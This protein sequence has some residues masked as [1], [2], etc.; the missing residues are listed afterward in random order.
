MRGIKMHKIKQTQHGF[1][2]TPLYRV[3]AGMVKRCE[4]VKCKG[5][6]Y[7]GGRGITLHKK[8]RD[9]AGLFCLWALD[10]GYK[11]GLEID[12]IDNDGDY[13]PDNCRFVTHRQNC[14]TGRRVLF[15]N[16]KTGMTGV[17]LSEYG[18]FRVYQQV[19]GK[20]KYIGV[21]KTLEEAKKVRMSLC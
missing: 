19:D 6:K 15:K 11:K 4:D 14:Q 9:N 13:A 8:W 7:Y 16:N 5:Y 12:R 10:N 21:Y 20:Q 2:G 3:W 17:S 18:T 1:H